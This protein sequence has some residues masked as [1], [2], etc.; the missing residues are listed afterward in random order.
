MMNKHWSVRFGQNPG[1]HSA[2]GFSI[3]K[4][5]CKS[6]G[7]PEHSV[8]L[9]DITNDPLDPFFLHGYAA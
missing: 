4:G 7:H 3:D 5:K 6:Q 9:I 8:F 1:A 2:Q